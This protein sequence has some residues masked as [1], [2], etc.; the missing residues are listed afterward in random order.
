MR[1][2]DCLTRKEKM[3]KPKSTL[4]GVAGHDLWADDSSP[5]FI[6][7]RVSLPIAGYIQ[8]QR[9]AGERPA[10]C[11]ICPAG[12]WVIAECDEQ[13]RL[14]SV[15]AD[16]SSPFGIVCTL[17]LHAAEIVHS[18]DRLCERGRTKLNAQLTPS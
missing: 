14:T 8:M 18:K 11:G 1:S 15:R 4:E 12:C 16:E 17:G 2:D 5:V 6:H 13:G 3:G 9:K 7:G 10:L